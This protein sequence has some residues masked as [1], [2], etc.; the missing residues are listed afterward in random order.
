MATM[1]ANDLT[2][3]HLG[4]R[5]EVASGNPLPFQDTLAGILKQVSHYQDRRDHGFIVRTRL[6][7]EALGDDHDIDI[8]GQKEVELDLD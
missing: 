3:S 8:L 4:T 5:I 1:A 6:R 7:I 2:G